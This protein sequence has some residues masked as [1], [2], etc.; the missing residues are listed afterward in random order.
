MFWIELGYPIATSADLQTHA[1]AAPTPPPPSIPAPPSPASL[2]PPTGSPPLPQY[3][4]QESPAPLK[5]P[6]KTKSPQKSLPDVPS[7]PLCI[8]VV[9]DDPMTRALMTRMLTRQGCVVETA[10]DGQQCLDIVTSPTARKY[11]LISLDNFMPVMTGEQAVRELRRL[12]RTDLVVG[13]T[14]ECNVYQARTGYLIA[15]HVYWVL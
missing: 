6:P 4:S 1:R 14:G 11:D 13:C 7:D 3:S 10:E 8:L 15:H 12:G 5:L 9:D 2:G